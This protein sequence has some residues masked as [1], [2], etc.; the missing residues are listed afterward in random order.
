MY[1]FAEIAERL[2]R[3]TVQ[4]FSGGR[5]RGG[6]S[7]VIWSANGLIVTNAHVVRS[8]GVSVR[9]WDGRQFYAPLIA[10][11]PRRD[12]AAVQLPAG[13]LP[14]LT[15]GDSDALRPGEVAVAVG[16]P[17]GF[18]GVL[19]TGVIHSVGS[20]PGM[21]RQSWVQATVRLAPGNSGGPLTDAKGQ[22]IGINTAIV[23][24]LGVAVP[25]ND[26]R[27][28]LRHAAH[29]RAEAA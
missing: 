17:L 14:A 28:F 16:N 15:A 12:L 23:Y 2:R 25:S 20:L 11:D 27:A 19:S 7:G 3:A 21:G 29:A 26:V 10:H 8:T 4:V 13:D 1:D 6:G 22:V 18:A 9:L 24:G 5:D